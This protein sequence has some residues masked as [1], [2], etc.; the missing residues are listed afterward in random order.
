[1]F[2]A[3]NKFKIIKE[4]K[5]TLNIFLINWRIMIEFTLFIF[6]CLWSFFL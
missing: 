3:M 4:K 6:A 2:I 5:S 1:M